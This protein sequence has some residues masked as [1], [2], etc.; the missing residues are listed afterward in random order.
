MSLIRREFPDVPDM[1]RR[2]FD[3]EASEKGWLRVEEFVDGNT[4]VI[5]ADLPGIDPD[6]DVDVSVSDGMLHIT[7][8][9]REKSEEKKKDFY[10][11]EFK[12]GSFGRSVRLPA[13]ATE[14]DVQASYH[15]GVLEVRVPLGDAPK[16][17][18]RKVPVTR[19][20]A[21]EVTP[22][23]EGPAET[24]PSVGAPGA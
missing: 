10:R 4:H 2:W 18:A 5:R 21:P 1:F 13:G 11:S 7:A 24:Q 14:D 19:G 6:K 23:P 17:E 20:A 9:R 12:Y 22:P 16:P 15:D 8:E 3:V